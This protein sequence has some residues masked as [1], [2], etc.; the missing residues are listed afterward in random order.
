MAGW[1]SFESRDTR[2]SPDDHNK[3]K[4]AR[5]V[6]AFPFRGNATLDQVNAAFKSDGEPQEPTA[7][8]PRATARAGLRTWPRA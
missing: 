1:A 4:Q 2:S 6:V 5:H 7:G 3:S 8:R